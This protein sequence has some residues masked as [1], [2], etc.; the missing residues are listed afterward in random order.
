[1]RRSRGARTRD[2][3]RGRSAGNQGAATSGAVSVDTEIAAGLCLSRL[4][5]PEEA[6]RR[7]GPWIVATMTE[8]G[9]T[10]RRYIDLSIERSID[11]LRR[12]YT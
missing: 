12:P 9:G 5:T 6:A 8:M 1:M 4:M 2:Q 10:D 11:L 3:R 7:T